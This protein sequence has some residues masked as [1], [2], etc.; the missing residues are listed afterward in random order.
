[1]RK[2]FRL[3]FAAVVVF[4]LALGLFGVYGANEPVVSCASASKTPLSTAPAT[5]VTAQDYFAQGDY[6]YE[7]G[8]CDKAIADYA[9]AIE[10]NPDFA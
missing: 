4:C 3:I 2:R 8:N 5:L 1:M 7:Q 6:D 9:R 10:L